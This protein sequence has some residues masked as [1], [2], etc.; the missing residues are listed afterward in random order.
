MILESWILNF[1][2]IFIFLLI[3]PNTFITEESQQHNKKTKQKTK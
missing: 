1:C 2:M 3:L